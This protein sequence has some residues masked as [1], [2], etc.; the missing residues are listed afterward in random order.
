[1]PVA[2]LNGDKTLGPFPLRYGKDPEIGLPIGSGEGNP[3][4]IDFAGLRKHRLRE[5][6]PL[7]LRQRRFQEVTSKGGISV[8]KFSL[9]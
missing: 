7:P 8:G 9:K 5:R 2:R 6:N 1:M 4:E 3:P